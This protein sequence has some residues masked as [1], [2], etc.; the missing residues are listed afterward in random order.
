MLSSVL[1]YSNRV[2]LAV[3]V[4]LLGIPWNDISAI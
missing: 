1:V 3:G 2:L 4:T